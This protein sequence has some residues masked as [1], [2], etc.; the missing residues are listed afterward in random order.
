MKTLFDSEPKLIP[1]QHAITSIKALLAWAEEEDIPA[2]T[3]ETEVG[4]GVLIGE[5]LLIVPNPLAASSQQ[6]RDIQQEG[7]STRGVATYYVYPWEKDTHKLLSHFKSKLGMDSRKYAAKRLLC[8]EITNK[9]GDAFMQAYHIQGLARGVDKVSIALRVKD[10]K[11][12]VAVQQFAKY[13]F[14]IR[15]GEGSI[16]DST[17]WEG[18]R[19]CFLPGVQIYGGA[20][21][22]QKYFEKHYTPTKVI[23][24]VSASHSLGEYK[25]S[26][27]FTDITDWNQLSYM[28]VLEGEPKVVPIKDKNGEVRVNDLEAC[29]KNKYLNPT[30]MAGAFGKGIGQTVYGGK[31]GSRKQLREHPENGELVHN[32]A[33]MEKIGWSKHWT[34]GQYKWVKEYGSE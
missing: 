23:S 3:E 13:R 16:K 29:R 26:Q 22:L 21:R 4:E 14:G 32:D 2:V 17:V 12:I 34:A 10:T 5:K 30:K 33:I 7:K 11:E 1:T 19:L 18:L 8:E 25:A 9:E 27:G 28:W 15:K 6:L 31:L 20:S 24:Y